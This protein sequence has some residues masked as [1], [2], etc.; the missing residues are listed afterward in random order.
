MVPFNHYSSQQEKISQL[1]YLTELPFL[2]KFYEV[3]ANVVLLA[4]NLLHSQTPASLPDLLWIAIWLG[5]TKSQS[6]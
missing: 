2:V 5:L 6:F 3:K 1:T 4:I